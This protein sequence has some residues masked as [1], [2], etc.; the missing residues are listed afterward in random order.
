MFAAMQ[1]L[2]P[3]LFQP[4]YQAY[5]WGGTRLASL[6]GRTGTGPVCAESWEIADRPDGM[7]VVVNGPLA[8]RTLGDLV[9]AEGER[10]LGTGVR[11]DRFPLLIKLIDARERLSVQVHPNDATAPRTGG[12]PKTEMWYVLAADRDAVVF[13]GL[14]P[15]TRRDRLEQ[16][17]RDQALEP[18]L[19]RT[20]VHPHTAIYIP[21]GC[22]HAIG[23]GCLLLE[24]QQNSNTTY[25]VHDWGRVDQDGRPR[26]LHVSEALTVVDLAMPA[27][28]LLEP[29][30]PP[31]DSATGR[32]V[33]RSPY[34]RIARVRGTQPLAVRH[35]GHS[36]HALFIAGGG[37][38]VT[39]GQ[40]T[41]TL[42]EGQ[43]CLVPAVCTDYVLQPGPE[44][45]DALR[46]TLG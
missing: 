3:L 36:F 1:A 33:L 39:A 31:M 34:F 17:I 41:T 14:V 27:P 35:A 13:A 2:Y 26:A 7:S 20:P 38:S 22:L 25:R 15:G 40:V 8:G 44:G 16:A 30:P 12:E 5:L 18:L 28:T 21:G 42:R 29:P 43:S 9:R 6:Y 4:V 45:L 24:V 19:A 32:E 37:G 23:A 46:I 11:A 10:L